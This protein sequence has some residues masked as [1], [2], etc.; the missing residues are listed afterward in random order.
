[1][2]RR[3][4]K[5]ISYFEYFGPLDSAIHYNRIELMDSTDY[6]KC[7]YSARTLMALY[8]K[9]GNYQEACRYAMAYVE[10]NDSMKS[11]LKIAQT[12]DANNEYQYYRDLGAE[13]EAYK[14][15]SKAR[16][17]LTLTIAL[18]I[19]VLLIVLTAYLSYQRQMEHKLYLHNQVIHWYR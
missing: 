5:Q 15:A 6:L 12:Q 7:C 10:A 13:T 8:L 18:A 17:H 2:I 16:L 11:Q 9:K 19:I 1:M 14:Q 4:N 3:K